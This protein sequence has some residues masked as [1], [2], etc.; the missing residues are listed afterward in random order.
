[1]SINDPSEQICFTPAELQKFVE[2]TVREC[3]QICEAQR[4]K[5]LQNQ[6]D[7]SWTEH[8]AEVQRNIKQRFGIK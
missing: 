5:I 3:L 1:M 4:Q 6:K 2:L 8:F 7:P